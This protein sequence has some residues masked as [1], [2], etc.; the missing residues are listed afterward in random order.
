MLSD[1]RVPFLRFDSTAFESPLYSLGKED[2]LG[3]REAGRGGQEGCLCDGTCIYL[4]TGIP[5]SSWGGRLLYSSPAPAELCLGT[6]WPSGGQSAAQRSGTCQIGPLQETSPRL[7]PR[8]STHG[9]PA[10]MRDTR[11]LLG[12][13]LRWPCQGA[14]CSHPSGDS[15]QSSEHREARSAA[16]PDLVS[17][18]EGRPP[19]SRA[20]PP[21]AYKWWP[22]PRR[23]RGG[24]SGGGGSRLRVSRRPVD[25][26]T[27]FHKAL[28]FQLQLQCWL[29]L[30]RRQRETPVAAL[31]LIFVLVV[32][33]G[34]AAQGC[35]AFSGAI[36][37]SSHSR[38]QAPGQEQLQQ[39]TPEQ[40][41][42]EGLVP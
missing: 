24:G 37:G 4:A 20:P 3:R 7:S 40:A 42:G 9:L 10:T 29:S 35:C 8:G 13:L 11:S 38:E 39:P 31:L 36:S 2:I 1:L 6:G 28:A 5:K 15:W 17:C 25:P 22:G 41:R 12:F 16:R 26:P 23:G 21:A 30:E 33:W 32:L 18:W 14:G 19:R 34:L 27:R